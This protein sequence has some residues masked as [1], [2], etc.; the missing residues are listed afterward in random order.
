[1]TRRGNRKNCVIVRGKQNTIICSQQKSVL[2][3][4]AFDH[5]L[6]NF[7]QQSILFD[8]GGDGQ[9]RFHQIADIQV[10][11][12]IQGAGFAFGLHL[13]RQILFL[14]R[15]PARRSAYRSEA[16]FKS[17]KG[18]K[19]RYRIKRFSNKFF[20]HIS[21]DTLFFTA[22]ERVGLRLDLD[23]RGCRQQSFASP[24]RGQCQRL[25]TAS[26]PGSTK[27]ANLRFWAVYS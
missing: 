15:I 1:M 18:S 21:D 7:F 24:G 19:H 10:G 6:L 13:H 27:F 23:G 8:L 11:K 12:R 20:T 25:L 3:P 17:S 26:L 5:H 14:F 16:I 4:R 2:R 9:G 22:Q